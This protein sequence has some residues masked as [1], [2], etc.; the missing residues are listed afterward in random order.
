MTIPK[1][2]A[3]TTSGISIGGIKGKVFPVMK[4]QSNHLPQPSSEYTTFPNA[5]HIIVTPM[6]ISDL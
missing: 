6:P 1:V 2:Q 3:A 4:N 5:A